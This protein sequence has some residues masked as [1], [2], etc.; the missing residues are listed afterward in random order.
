MSTNLKSS[1]RNEFPVRIGIEVEKLRIDKQGQVSRKYFPAE[2][3]PD[4]DRYIG[5]EYFESQIEFALP[6]QI[7]VQANIEL[8]NKVINAVGAQLAPDEQLWPYSC[9]PPLIDR[10]RQEMISTV[11]EETNWYRQKLREVY[12][13]RRIMNCGVH[14]NVSLNDD[15]VETLLATTEFDDSNALY[16]HVA[17]Q[18]MVFQW[19]FTYLFGATPICYSGYLDNQELIHPVRSV[20][21]SVLGFPSSI[22]GDYHSLDGYVNKIEDAISEGEILRSNQYYESVRCKS[23]LGK[24]PKYLLTDG[25]SHLEVRAFDLNP[26]TI[27]GVTAHQLRLVGLLTIFFATLPSLGN[28]AFQR[29]MVNMRKLNNLVAAEDPRKDSICRERGLMLMGQLDRFSQRYKIND[30]Y[31]K[32]IE[33]FACSFMDSKQSLAYQ[34]WQLCVEKNEI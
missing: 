24:S 34:T 21:R 30:A 32:S 19:A 27:S 9:P 12:D 14:L 26:T 4:L 8:A 3:A 31:R 2:I 7:D 1:I 20:R 29:K 18:F 6:P 23:N 13:I 22:K 17:Q 10:G 33:H 25:I 11:P 16:L 28:Q 5:R 15:A